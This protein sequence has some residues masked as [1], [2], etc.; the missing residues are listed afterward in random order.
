MDERKTY[1]FGRSAYEWYVHNPYFPEVLQGSGCNTIDSCAPTCSDAE[2]LQYD[3]PF[4]TSPLH[5]TVANKND[6]R[7]FENLITHWSQN[8][9]IRF[10]IAK[11]Y[12]DLYIPTPI[13][14]LIQVAQSATNLELY[15]MISHLCSSFYITS[16]IDTSLERRRDS[17]TL[18]KIE[19]FCKLYSSRKG[20]RKLL[21]ATRH[22]FENAASPK[23]IELALKLTLPS[24]L[25]GLC[26]PRP[27]LNYKIEL[28]E[29]TKNL[30]DSSYYV[31]DACWPN[32]KILL[33]YD[34]DMAHLTSDQK[35]HDEI[36]RRTL[37]A[38]GYRIFVVTRK[39]L[40]SIAQM[41]N[42]ARLILK[43]MGKQ[44]RHRSKN[45]GAASNELYEFYKRKTRES[46]MRHI[47]QQA[48]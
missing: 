34:S 20:A 11:A 22:A 23:E 38:Q 14:A 29:N 10:T 42:T 12:R 13:V 18:K 44:F 31:A 39:Q 4:L 6:T 25:G 37:E 36:K 33:E 41:E 28:L 40:S 19:R 7:R 5:V 46:A 35:N 32:E 1:L 27:L 48:F 16:G 47:Q 26:V 15:D 9:P 17:L 30:T 24:K 43:A 3:M 45:F 21:N 2:S 8:K